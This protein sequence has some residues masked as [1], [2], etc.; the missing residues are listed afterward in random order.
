MSIVKQI[1]DLHGGEVE[2]RSQP[3]QGTTVTTRWPLA[4]R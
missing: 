1:V 4:W 2:V 3:G